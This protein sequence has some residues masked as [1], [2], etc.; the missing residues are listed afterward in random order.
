MKPNSG[1]IS[2]TTWYQLFGNNGRNYGNNQAWPGR[3]FSTYIQA[4]GNQ[5]TLH[6]CWFTTDT[7][8]A[9]K[10]CWE[11]IGTEQLPVDQWSHVCITY[12]ENSWNQQSTI[13]IY[14]NGECKRTINNLFCM[15]S[16]N[17]G[18]NPVGYYPDTVAVHK[19]TQV[20]INDFRVYNHCLSVKE[21]KDLAQG[22]SGYYN[23]DGVV[24]RNGGSI[25][26]NGTYA[27]I[28]ETND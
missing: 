24:T 25:I 18:Y 6:V 8:D 17:N 3:F 20:L 5:R 22:M 9:K 23:F 15:G 12:A 27:E 13:K 4:S 14:I 28:D 11:T 16:T 26:V 7:N 19:Q 21:I 1:N 2:N 10:L